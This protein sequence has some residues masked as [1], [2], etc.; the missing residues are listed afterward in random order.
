MKRQENTHINF[1]G[2][3]LVIRGRKNPKGKPPL[4]LWDITGM[5]YI[6]SLYDTE[7]KETKR[8]EIGGRYYLLNMST[9]KH[10]EVDLKTA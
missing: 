9:G 5:K 4:Y 2:N 7:T 1:E 10:R 6:S 3:N 8:F